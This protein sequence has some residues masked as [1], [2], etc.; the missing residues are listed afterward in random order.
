MKLILD[1]DN[2]VVN[3]FQDDQV[4]ELSEKSLTTT[5]YVDMTVNSNTH[6]IVSTD[7]ELPNDYFPHVYYYTNDD[8]IIA[9]SS[10]LNALL[11]PISNIEEA[12]ALA[13]K[14]RD[15]LLSESDWTQLA[16]SPVN[17]EAWASYRQ[18]LRDVPQQEGFPL[19]IVWPQK[20]E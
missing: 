5:S 3:A 10:L 14:T 12:I 13:R 19:N 20:P 4:F 7:K 16:D 6:S 15:S 1:R 2:L 9:N 17:K 11:N 18:S 8:F